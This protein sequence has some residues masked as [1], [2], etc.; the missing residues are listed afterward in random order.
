MGFLYIFFGST[1]SKFTAYAI[2]AAIVA[3]CIT[4]LL[5]RTDMNIS[6]KILL[7][8]FVILTLVPSVFLILFEITCMVTGGNKEERWW[9]WLYAWVISAFIIIYCILIVII[10]FTSLFTYNNAIDRVEISENQNKMSPENSNDYAK[11]MIETSQ[12][13]E[14][15]ENSIDDKNKIISVNDINKIT[16]SIDIKEDKNKQEI[17]SD[18]LYNLSN[19]NFDGSNE[20]VSKPLIMENKKEISKPNM[21]KKKEEEHKE[22]PSSHI[23][24]LYTN[25][26]KSSSSPIDIE[27]F[28][29]KENNY[30]NY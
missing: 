21:E 15:F 28:T 6:N 26:S 17:N 22:I 30:S 8:F 1:Q 13:L 14:R 5:T 18:P 27:P 23:S 4:I 25:T 29:L 3:I 20:I 2:L 19:E 24:S 9:C 12:T 16:N 10:S 7:I 11:T